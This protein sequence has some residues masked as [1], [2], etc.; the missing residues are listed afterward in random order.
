MNNRTVET[1]V[2]RR[3]YEA[4]IRLFAKTGTTDI[5]ISQLAKEADVARNTVYS[6]VESVDALFH[7]VAA[8]VTNE[9]NTRVICSVSDI[10]GPAARVAFGIRFYVRRAYDE[11]HWGRFIHTFGS[12]MLGYMDFI[13]GVIADDIRAGIES[14]EYRI[15]NDM[16]SGAVNLIS[17]VTFGA[18]SRVVSGHE[19]WRSAGSTAAELTLRAL[20]VNVKVAKSR[21]YEELPPLLTVDEC[22]ADA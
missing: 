13:G 16:V 1:A 19:A 20:G 15:R 11:P 18:I 4:A 3:I 9:M 7:H 6:Y 5:T 17:S 21:A 14:G 12:R 8:A 10:K 2:Q 22:K